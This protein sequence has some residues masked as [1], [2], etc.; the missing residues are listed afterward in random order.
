MRTFAK[1]LAGFLVTLAATGW[2]L[3]NAMGEGTGALADAGEEDGLGAFSD[4]KATLTLWYTDDALTDYLNRE[5][6]RYG[7]VSEDVRV[8]PVLVPGVGFLEAVGQSSTLGEAFPDLYITTH[9]NL[10]KAALAGLAAD[11]ERP[12]DNLRGDNYSAAA[13]SS[14]NWH[15]KPIA[16]PFYC[17]TTALLYNRTYLEDE[18]RRMA[19]EE[20]I[21]EPDAEEIDARVEKMLPATLEDLL[22]FAGSYNAPDEVEAVFRFDVNDLFTSYFFAGDALDVGGPDG[23]D[24]EVVDVYNEKVLTCMDIYQQSG[25]FFATSSNAMNGEAILQD[26]LD[27]KVVFTVGTT[28]AVRRISQSREEGTCSFSFGAAPLFSLTED[29]GTRALSVTNCIVI[30]D[31][32]ENISQAMRFGRFLTEEGTT[33]LYARTGKLSARS[34]AEFGE[35]PDVAGMMRAYAQVYEHSVPMPKMLA[36]SNFWIRLEIAFTDIWN[37]ANVNETMRGVSEQLLMQIRG[38]RT[39]VPPIEDPPKVVISEELSEEGEE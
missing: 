3:L 15:G 35:D 19:L 18:A 5:A 22:S 7:S 6:A 9:D 33:E 4:Q 2:V 16:Y 27:G 30:N 24:P 8:L 12:E 39:E 25:Q 11:I 37:G 13:L 28:E 17:E 34:R 29:L 10:E 26:F 38:T 36:T 23:D 32:S 20:G 14:V 31:F 21:E 1:R